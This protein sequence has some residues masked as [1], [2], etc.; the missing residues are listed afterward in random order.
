MNQ[1]HHFIVEWQ[2]F[3]PA[4]VAEMLEVTD[5]FNPVK[6]LVPNLRKVHVASEGSKASY[7]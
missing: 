1:R 2:L 4:A 5:G 3:S 6:V 7:V